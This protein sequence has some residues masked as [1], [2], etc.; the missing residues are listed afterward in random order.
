MFSAVLSLLII[1]NCF[2]CHAQEYFGGGAESYGLEHKADTSETNFYRKS[3]HAR[4]RLNPS[5]N[6]LVRNEAAEVPFPE[7]VSRTSVDINSEEESGSSQIYYSGHDEFEPGSAEAVNVGS[8][9]G[10]TNR[11]NTKHSE[12][13]AM[14]TTG[15]KWELM[16]PKSRLGE[17]ENIESEPKSHVL[18]RFYTKEKFKRDVSSGD[19]LASGDNFIKEG[20]TPRTAYS[21]SAPVELG[22]AS[23]ISRELDRDIFS[24]ARSSDLIGLDTDDTGS[25]TRISRFADQE[26]QQ[27]FT[28]LTKRDTTESGSSVESS[29]HSSAFISGSDLFSKSDVFGSDTDQ[30]GIK[31]ASKQMLN[32]QAI[33]L[34]EMETTDKSGSTS[35]NSDYD[36]PLETDPE[37]P[38]NSDFARPHMDDTTKIRK[39]N[40]GITQKL[41]KQIA[42]LTELDTSPESGSLAESSGYSGTFIGEPE[43]PS[44]SDLLGSSKDKTSIKQEAKE[45]T[46]Q[47]LKKS[48]ELSNINASDELG[49]S[50]E[51]LDG[52]S[53][54]ILQSSE[55]EKPSESDLLGSGTDQTSM[56]QDPTQDLI[57]K[58]IKPANREISGESGSSAE[59]S[60][61]GSTLPNDPNMATN[62]D[63]ARQNTD[64]EAITQSI[65]NDLSELDTSGESGSSPTN[66]GDGDLSE[67]SKLEKAAFFKE[68][69]WLGIRSE[70][71][72]KAQDNG[73]APVVLRSAF[74]SQQ[75]ED[76]LSGET[77]D[78]EFYTVERPSLVLS[79]DT[80][81][82][83]GWIHR[84]H[85]RAI[86][87]EHNDSSGD[88]GTGL[89]VQELDASSFSG[90]LDAFIN[91]AVTNEA[92]ESG[93]KSKVTL[94]MLRDSLLPKNITDAKETEHPDHV[95]LEM[96]RKS[97]LPVHASPEKDSQDHSGSASHLAASQSEDKA[98]ES[99]LYGSNVSQR[100]KQE[101]HHSGVGL[102][103][104][105]PDDS[106]FSGI[107]DTFIDD[108]VTNNAEEAGSKRKVTLDMLRDSLL[109][110]NI[111]FTASEENEHHDHVTLETLRKSLLK[112]NAN[113]EKESQDHSGFGGH[114]VASQSEEKENEVSVNGSVSERTK[115]ERP[116][117]RIALVVQKP[118]DS[119]FSGKLDTLIDDAGTNKAEES[120]GK[121][122][123]TLAML[124]DS[125]LIK[126]MTLTAVKENKHRDKVTLEML[127][128][129]LLPIN[130]NSNK[131]SQ[132][133]SGSANDLTG[134]QSAE[135]ENEASANSS[136]VPER[137]NE[138]HHSSDIFQKTGKAKDDTPEHLIRRVLAGE[139][140][141]S[142]HDIFKAIHSD[143][144]PNTSG[145]EPLDEMTTKL[146][147]GRPFSSF[148]R[149][150]H[151]SQD[152]LH[153][154]DKQM[155]DQIIPKRT[156]S[157]LGPTATR[158]R[159]SE[160]GL[161][162]LKYRGAPHR[163]ILKRSNNNEVVFENPDQD[164][165]FNAGVFRRT[166]A[167]N[168]I[169]ESD[170]PFDRSYHD[171][172]EEL[173]SPLDNGAWHRGISKRSTSNEDEL[174]VK[175][176]G[177]EKHNN[178]REAITNALLKR[179]HKDVSGYIQNMAT[180][181]RQVMGEA[182]DVLVSTD[183]VVHGL[184]KVISGANK[185]TNFADNAVKYA[186]Y[187]SMEPT[188]A[189]VDFLEEK[190][191]I[192]V[193]E[194]QKSAA[195]A[196]LAAMVAKDA[197]QKAV[198]VA[199]RAG[200]ASKR[201]SVLQRFMKAAKFASVQALRSAKHAGIA[202]ERQKAAKNDALVVDKALRKM[203][204][205]I[206]TNR[207][208]ERENEVK[209]KLLKAMKLKQL[210]YS[211]SDKKFQ[212]PNRIGKAETRDNYVKGIQRISSRMRTNSVPLKD[213]LHD[214]FSNINDIIKQ[215]KSG[216]GSYGRARAVGSSKSQSKSA[217]E[218]NDK[219]NMNVKSEREDD[220]KTHKYVQNESGPTSA[221]NNIRNIYENIKSEI[222]NADAQSKL[223]PTSASSNIRTIYE[224]IK[225]EIENAD[226]NQQIR[227]KLEFSTRGGNIAGIHN[228]KI[229]VSP[230]NSIRNIYQQIK[231]EIEKADMATK[232]NRSY[233][234]LAGRPYQEKSNGKMFQKPQD[235]PS[236]DDIKQLF[237]SIK[238][239]IENATTG[240]RNSEQTIEKPFQRSQTVPS[241]DDI[242]QLFHGIKDEIENATTGSHQ[243]GQAIRK[244][245]QKS[246]ALPAMS[247]I[248]KLYHSIKNE[249]ENATVEGP[250]AFIENF[251]DQTDTAD[252]EPL[253]NKLGSALPNMTY[254]FGGDINGKHGQR[255]STQKNTANIKKKD[256][257][258][259][260]MG[261][262]KLNGGD[263]ENEVVANDYTKSTNEKEAAVNDF[264]KYIQKV[265]GSPLKDTKNASF[266]KKDNREPIEVTI[267]INHNLKNGQK[268]LG[269]RY[270]SSINPVV[271]VSK[272]VTI[273]GNAVKKDRQFFPEVQSRPRS[274]GI[275]K[276]NQ[277]KGYERNL[278]NGKTF[279][280]VDHFNFRTVEN[281]KE[282]T[283]N[284][285]MIIAYP[286][287]ST[288]LQTGKMMT[289]YVPPKWILSD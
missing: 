261:V 86:G 39:I 243:S 111:T 130:G 268:K 44:K 156:L 82:P 190:A 92:E 48:K 105:E 233:A 192:A 201:Q 271:Q 35:D 206:Q 20:S 163:I 251:R 235:V 249:I 223:G 21:L 242:R 245:F 30:T 119:N 275:F 203:I 288:G 31:K 81:M 27:E 202:T 37:K 277:Q 178:V 194:A 129:S 126:N 113:P 77:E 158:Y 90:K 58:S 247:G 99:S 272:S 269:E 122:K 225:K 179:H 166:I 255:K 289:G 229:S 167:N 12:S 127:R 226:E 215:I 67:L 286:Q 237:H 212:A 265:N 189:T 94:G 165:M 281:Q 132:D 207:E 41:D 240:G 239:E 224:K 213:N 180:N 70:A 115:Q 234:G 147:T 138:E 84:R 228:G 258:K 29:G 161:D 109:L 200:I 133:H 62:S 114:L 55:P 222:E 78:G 69:E 40:N 287:Q 13:N 101:R 123:V 106:N 23:A 125:L 267:N 169:A 1:L 104:Q 198:N 182:K 176:G 220:K 131:S 153:R 75:M 259:G 263:D 42:D 118:D 191:V 230:T 50:A 154:A 146:L 285:R 168:S 238:D 254:N 282:S 10:S 76:F 72:A 134:F 52:S 231:D 145:S 171:Y 139:M 71:T 187:F 112:K 5:E 252:N 121:R 143:D 262:E 24:E 54:G 95:M 3:P 87:S 98:T 280:S 88:S 284:R 248:R 155:L 177:T 209:S 117:S 73:K 107:L 260:I 184:R 47:D 110:K 276:A 170:S 173:Y 250:S 246:Q 103:V 232:T 60:D 144:Q 149:P 152:T 7:M 273:S 218:Y 16:H 116:N 93:S 56:R 32:K 197:A 257:S 102:V 283:V 64:P 74:P 141:K 140:K 148:E 164:K 199:K 204:Q 219:T 211:A 274:Q 100:T 120:A 142:L 46:D 266:F 196:R 174:K 14:L 244:P 18:E 210:S 57:E 135:K 2:R 227:D 236:I 68:R 38:S 221:S 162:S 89:V 33:E 65:N 124:R 51:S 85:V 97:L 160:D 19:I 181:V 108:A 214:T 22:S 186:K 80:E 15:F 6:Y 34:T 208:K 25:A 45:A 83:E 150:F 253:Q 270:R 279:D 11:F 53:S 96:L 8:G 256:E 159:D 91:D 264:V 4:I 188:N 193:L 66:S 183:K 241:L 28:E 151:D 205:T 26:A 172:V 49:S 43:I 9:F 195:E 79:D 217:A 128:K 216:V 137:T 185:L 36:G 61:Y 136:N 59:S 278:I 157:Y 63:L 175:N 17:S